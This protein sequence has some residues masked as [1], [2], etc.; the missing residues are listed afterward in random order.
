MENA[1]YFSASEVPV[2]LLGLGT[3]RAISHYFGALI[4]N[5]LSQVRTIIP[6]IHTSYECVRASPIQKIN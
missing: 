5:V 6:T 1:S 3:L 4:N 2:I